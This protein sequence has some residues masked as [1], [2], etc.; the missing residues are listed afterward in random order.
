MTEAASRLPVKAS[1]KSQSARADNRFPFDNLR[2]E[3]DRLFDDFRPFGWRLPSHR[4]VFDLD[5]PTLS[6]DDWF[7]VPAID[8][9]ERDD[10]FEIT[11]ELPG[12][13]DKDVEIKLANRVMTIKAVKKENKQ[14]ERK[15]YHVSE[16]RYG[17]FQRNF[18]IPES[19]NADQI[20]A[21][22]A[23]GVLTVTM[24]KSPEAQKSEKKIQV[25]AAEK[26]PVSRPQF[27]SPIPRPAKEVH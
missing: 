9:V 11:A 17:S 18:E 12:I 14:E 27:E 20:S 19:V 24:P 6:R 8:V 7:M 15:D 2:R 26:G 22:F 16:R 5:L 10:Q 13:D 21:T 3:I 23:K 1:T 25:K 4:S